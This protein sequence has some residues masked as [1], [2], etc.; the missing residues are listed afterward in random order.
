M[1]ECAHDISFGAAPDVQVWDCPFDLGESVPTDVE[2]TLT[3]SLTSADPLCVVNGEDIK[4]ELELTGILAWQTI[5]EGTPLTIPAIPTGA[6]SIGV[7][8]TSHTNV[9]PLDAASTYTIDGVIG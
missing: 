1:I 2:F 3:E 4:W 6:Q 5:E 8:A 9:C 7:K